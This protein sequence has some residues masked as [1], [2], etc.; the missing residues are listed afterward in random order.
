MLSV[1]GVFQIPFSFLGCS[2][3]GETCP[4]PAESA[5]V[6]AEGAGEGDL[7]GRGVLGWAL[8]LLCSQ[9]PTALSLPI[10]FTDCCI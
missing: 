9:G 8:A 5:W 10:S 1:P 6:L 2:G 4:V 7:L 3:R